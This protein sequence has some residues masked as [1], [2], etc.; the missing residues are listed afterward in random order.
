M[1]SSRLLSR[2]HQKLQYICSD[3]RRWLAET[4]LPSQQQ[5]NITQNALRKMQTAEEEWLIRAEE[6][7]NGK[8]KSVLE[9]L[10]E[11]GL[12]NQI[13]GN[14][15]ALDKALIDRRV[16]AYCGVDPTAASLHIGHMI[17][18]MALSWMF[19]HGYQS[20]FL[21]SYSFCDRDRVLTSSR[22]ADLP[23][24][25]ATLQ[26]DSLRDRNKPEHNEERT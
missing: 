15:D 4:S 3:C 16:G 13:I 19:I 14:R 6:I 1:V 9:K 10:E 20:T 5:R 22:L 26:I 18:L 2:K 8:R 24:Q 11:R 7:R 23:L 21:V 25:L 17:P 12:V